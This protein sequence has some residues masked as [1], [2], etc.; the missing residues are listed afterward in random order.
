MSAPTS[1]HH[2]ADRVVRAA[3]LHHSA[4]M[5]V[6]PLIDVLLVLLIIFMAALPLTQQGVDVNVPRTVQQRQAP[7]D[8]S[9]VV[10]EYE[11]GRLTINRQPVAMGDAEKRF[12]EIF[13]RRRDKTLYVMAEKTS[14][15]GEV[16]AIIDAAKAAGVTRLGIVTEGMRRAGLGEK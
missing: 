8:V 6:T 7:V 2:G 10:A 13:A 16:I 4:E 3:P 9:H 15:Y 5:N 14:R 12:R 1:R 11:A